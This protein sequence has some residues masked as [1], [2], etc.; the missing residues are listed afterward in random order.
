MAIIVNS[1]NIITDV[2]TEPVT[3]SEAKDWMRVTYD[4][5]D[6]IIT[7]LIIAARRHI[8]FLCGVSF[9]VKTLKSNI[10]LTGSVPNAWM[11]DVPYSPLI[12]VSEIKLKTGFN[13]YDILVLNDD[14]EIIGGKIWL[15]TYGNYTITYQAGYSTMPKDIK[16]D[17]LTLV[18]WSYQNRGKNFKSDQ[19]SSAFKEYPTWNGL[20][21]NQYKKVVI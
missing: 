5:D 1:V 7:S 13:L 8:E 11:V 6:T 20:N 3:L 21:Y 2:I 9:A 16:N 15:Y 19:N 4:T 10:D 14:Y 18:A 17:I 12:T